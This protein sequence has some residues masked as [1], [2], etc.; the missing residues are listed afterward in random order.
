MK[1]MEKN[2]LLTRRQDEKDA[3]SMRVYITDNGRKMHTDIVAARKKMEADMFRGFTDEE[4]AAWWR[5]V[6]HMCA[7]LREETRDP[8]CSD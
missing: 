8:A 1:R 4:K 5:L 3:R 6:A 2:G 7:N